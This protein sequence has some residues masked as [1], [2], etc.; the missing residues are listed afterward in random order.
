MDPNGQEITRSPSPSPVVSHYPDVSKSKSNEEY[1]QYDESTRHGHTCCFVCCDT[2]TAC[3]V[4][5]VMSLAFTGLGLISLAPQAMD[6]PGFER[7]GIMIAAFVLGIICNA[8]GLY[9]ALKFRKT[10][11]LV[12]TV[13]FGIEAIL[14]VALFMDPVG[15]IVS[16]LFLYPHLM[17]FKELQSGVM[18]RKNYIHEKECCGAI[19]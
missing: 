7:F 8:L 17:F 16:I 3:L 1:V 15:F 11:I 14:S 18:S 2:R 5:N 13:W 12:A 4:V 19:C 9:G 6:R 10:F